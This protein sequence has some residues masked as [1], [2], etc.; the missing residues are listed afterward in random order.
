MA[1]S[2]APSINNIKARKGLLGL[3]ACTVGSVVSSSLR[4]RLDGCKTNRQLHFP[5]GRLDARALAPLAAIVV[6]ASVA[7]SVVCKHKS[8]GRPQHITSYLQGVCSC[9]CRC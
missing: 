8:S 7:E 5:R 1:V 4:L 2:I 9:G 6:L 3:L